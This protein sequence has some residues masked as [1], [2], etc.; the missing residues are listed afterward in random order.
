MLFNKNRKSKK[1][2]NHSKNIYISFEKM[3][4]LVKV[5]ISCVETGWAHLTQDLTS[6]CVTY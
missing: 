5:K 4:L 1:V 6:P 2:Q 3:V